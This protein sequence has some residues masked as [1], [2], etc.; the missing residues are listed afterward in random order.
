MQLDSGLFLQERY[1]RNQYIL[2]VMSRFSYLQVM[3]FKVG[4]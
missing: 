1:S 2:F 4:G 3:R